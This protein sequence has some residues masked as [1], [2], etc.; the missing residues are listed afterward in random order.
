MAILTQEQWR[1][2]SESTSLSTHTNRKAPAGFARARGLIQV[3]IVRYTLQRYER[4]NIRMNFP[5]CHGIG[6]KE[7]GHAL[8]T[9]VI[10]ELFVQHGHDLSHLL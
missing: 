2:R 10:L 6:I 3:C 9:R 4:V 1:L 7:Q 5:C 8:Q